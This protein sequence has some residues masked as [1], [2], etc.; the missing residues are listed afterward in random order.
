MNIYISMLRGIN[1]GRNKKIKMK[2][3]KVL[4]ESLNFKNVK[5]YIQSGNVVFKFEDLPPSKLREK[6]ENKI[7]E[8]FGFDVMV[9]IRTKNEFRNIINDNPFSKED[10]KQLHVTFLSDTPF[11][12]PFKEIDLKKDE[13]EKFSIIA[14]EVYLFL[15]NGYG[16]TKLSTG[17]FQ[18]KLKVSATNR[19]WRTVNKLYDIANEADIKK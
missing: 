19:N 17:F 4:Y 11:E 2:E 3:L 7:K 6:I 12:M 18:K 1:V 9:F 16:R 8:V 10:P 14:K 5:T 15:P 13:A